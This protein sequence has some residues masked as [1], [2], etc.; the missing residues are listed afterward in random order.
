[1]KLK[2]LSLLLMLTLSSTSALAV[3]CQS[4]TSDL[5]SMGQQ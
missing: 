1:M 5:P 2:S 3:T 4:N